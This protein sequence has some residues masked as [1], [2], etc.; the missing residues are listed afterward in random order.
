MGSGSLAAMAV[1]ESGWKPNL[2]VRGL[3]D[4]LPVTQH[5]LA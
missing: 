1:F 2:E 5:V 3:L 4:G